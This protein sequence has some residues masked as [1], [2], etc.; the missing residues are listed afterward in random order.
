M[1]GVLTLLLSFSLIQFGCSNGSGGEAKDA[2]GGT[3]TNT[4]S[5]E[6]SSKAIEGYSTN[7]IETKAGNKVSDVLYLLDGGKFELHKNLS[8]GEFSDFALF[9]KGSYSGNILTD[10]KLTFNVSEE[11]NTSSLSDEEKTMLGLSDTSAQNA[12]VRSARAMADVSLGDLIS[13]LKALIKKLESI[14][15]KDASKQLQIKSDRDGIK[16]TD[17]NN[18]EWSVTASALGVK[19]KLD[20]FLFTGNPCFVHENDDWRWANTVEEGAFSLTKIADG[21]YSCS[22]IANENDT[23]IRLIVANWKSQYGLSSID[24]AN[25][26][27]PRG[28]R[29][30]NDTEVVNNTEDNKKYQDPENIALAGIEKRRKYDITFDTNKTPGKICIELKRRAISSLD[31]WMI[32][33]QMNCIENA[34]K[35]TRWP[36]TKAEGALPLVKNGDKWTCT[37]TTEKSP[38]WCGF[39]LMKEEWTDKIGWWQL[40]FEPETHWVYGAFCN[41]DEYPYSGKGNDN[42]IVFRDMEFTGTEKVTLTFTVRSDGLLDIDCDIEYDEPFDLGG[43]YFVQDGQGKP[44]LILSNGQVSL[45]GS[46]WAQIHLLEKIEG[47]PPADGHFED[48]DENHNY[49]YYDGGCC[50][51]DGSDYYYFKSLSRYNGANDI[52]PTGVSTESGSYYML[53]SGLEENKNY[54]LTFDTTSKK[55]YFSVRIE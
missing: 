44:T 27:L 11:M 29:I 8:C 43:L 1:G 9:A 48:S 2:G 22:F 49:Y 23:L 26:V 38:G 39:A 6:I 33:G 16:F 46:E 31:G 30:T 20:N 17:E 12:G 3:S 53:I 21:K 4:S 19:I 50:W 28:V 55:G 40:A 24:V 42:N 14:E 36:N 13:K 5:P 37:F 15:M 52:L 41:D 35:T 54:T 32:S 51:Y 18:T 7:Q 45:V 10:G 47:E 34:D 25:S